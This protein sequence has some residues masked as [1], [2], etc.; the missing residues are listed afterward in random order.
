MKNLTTITGP[1]GD[2]LKAAG[3]TL[4]VAE[5][6]TGGLISASLLAVPG[7]SAYFTGGS[8]IYSL[9][10]RKVLLQIRSEDFEGLEP[11]TEAMAMRFAQV[12]RAQ[13]N[14]TWAIAELGVAGPGAARY[15]HPA[16]MT[17]IAVD[18]P[19]S[20]AITVKTDSANREENMWAFS[21]AA[22][23]LLGE[24]VE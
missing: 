4:C 6:S 9:R 8:V 12:A 22:L 1:V 24:L 16:G 17:V 10:S 3:Q 19:V 14:T 20:R 2:R 21:D 11:L 15:G 18:G 7:A 5:S 23:T 13:L